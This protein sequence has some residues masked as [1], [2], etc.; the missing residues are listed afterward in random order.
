[1][2]FLYEAKGIEIVEVGSRS[3]YQMNQVATYFINRLFGQTSET[4]K[5]KAER[6]KSEAI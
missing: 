5:P 6:Q 1:M 4:E 3:K 2:N